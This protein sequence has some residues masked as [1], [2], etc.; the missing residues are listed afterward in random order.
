MNHKSSSVLTGGSLAL[1]VLLIGLTFASS[2]CGPGLKTFPPSL[3]NTLFQP[4]FGFF[5]VNYPSPVSDSSV[6]DFYSRLRYDDVVFERNDSG[7]AAHYQFSVSV[8]S[9][10][11]LTDLKYSK[12][13]DRRI[14]VPSY[15]ETN[16]ITRFDTLGDR[17]TLEPGKYYIVLKLLDLNTGTTSAREF[18]HDFKNF[19]Q[20]PVSISDVLLFHSPD[21]TGIPITAIKGREDTLLADFYVTTKDAPANIALRVVAKSVEVPT[22][23]DTTLNLALSSRVVHYHVPIELASLEPGPYV[24]RVSVTRGK[25]K[26]SSE[27]YFSITRSE[28]P[29]LPAE[30]NAD[31]DPLIYIAPGNIVAQLKK[32]TFEQ[33]KEKFVQFWLARAHGDSALAVA[34]REEF[35]KRVDYV[36]NR[37]RGGLESGWRSDQ[38]RI[39]IIYGPPDQVDNH[40]Q[41]FNSPAYQ[42]W[43]YYNLHLEF[44]FVD[45]FGTGDYRL[46]QES[47][48]G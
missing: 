25:D 35:Y 15:A 13:F 16:S 20:D 19:L 4:R 22:Q 7:F 12:I 28:M 5:I 9:D 8:F 18:T 1:S 6:A 31:V 36:N 21:T 45:E 14:Q 23:I 3:K 11:G 47:Q 37:L 10:K 34:M 33:R 39:Y 32:G 30:L 43:Y 26:S 2:G 48:I 44:V 17:M 24:L 42:I 38:G 41:G 40:D 46:V 29:T 27:A